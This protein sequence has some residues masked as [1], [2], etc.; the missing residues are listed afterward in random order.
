MNRKFLWFGLG[1]VGLLA[2]LILAFITARPYQLHGSQLVPAPRAPDFSLTDQNGQLFHLGTQQNRISLIFFGYTSCPDICPATLSQ[3]RQLVQR[4]GTQADQVD[5]VYI[6][7]DP[8]RDTAQRM[9]EYVSAFNPAFFGLSG[10]EDELK[11]VWMAYGVERLIRTTDDPTIY[12]IDHT[13]RTYLVDRKGNLRLTF[14]YGTIIEDM[15]EDIRYL[16]G[17]G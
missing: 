9:K 14:P 11:A 2:V 4:L 16:L 3:F 6:T 15:L 5:F 12:F 8:K 1:V 10:T 13:S 17:E 7:V